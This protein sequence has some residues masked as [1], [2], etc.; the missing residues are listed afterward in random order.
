MPQA[1]EREEVVEAEVLR[2]ALLARLLRPKLLR[3]RELDEEPSA[4]LVLRA[5][6]RCFWDRDR[7]WNY[8]GSSPKLIAAEASANGACP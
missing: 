8:A 2:G 1:R 5:Q 4:A 3:L 7:S 6:S